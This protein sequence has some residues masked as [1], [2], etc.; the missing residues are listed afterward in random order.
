MAAVDV[1]AHVVEFHLVLGFPGVRL[2]E[3]GLPV[4]AFGAG[5][6]VRPGQGGVADHVGH[7]VGQLVHLVHDLVDVDA[8]VVGQLLV[9]AVPARVQ[10]HLVLLVLLRVQHVVALLAEPDPHEARAAVAG[11]VLAAAVLLHHR[12]SLTD[13]RPTAPTSPKKIEP[14]SPPDAAQ[15]LAS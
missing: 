10:Q 1:G 4:L 13:T 7:D 9:V 12:F 15:L 3:D 11:R 2:E 14:V 6:V 8:V 5:V